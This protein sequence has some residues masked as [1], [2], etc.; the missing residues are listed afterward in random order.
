LSAK[1]EYDTTRF[2][3][4]SILLQSVNLEVFREK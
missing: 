2:S 1:K 3:R 4:S